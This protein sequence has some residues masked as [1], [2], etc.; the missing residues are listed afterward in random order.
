LPFFP[1][2]DDRKIEVIDVEKLETL[3][4]NPAAGTRVINFWATWCKP[5]VEELPYFEALRDKPA[6]R[7]VEV[8]LISLDFV[9]DL[10]SK[11]IKFINKRNIQSTVMLLDNTD[12]NIWID[13]VDP[14]WSGAIPATLIVNGR[15]G[16]RVFFEKQFE[17]GELEDQLSKFI[18]PKKP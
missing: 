16:N 8:I 18:N 7:Q 10:D 3:I 6:F 11:V 1:G 13:K 2:T 5:C 12:Y 17:E 9:S 15:T 14:S 4:H